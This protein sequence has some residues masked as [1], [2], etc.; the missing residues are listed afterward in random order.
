MK[1]LSQVKSSYQ[2][3][4]MTFKVK[5]SE[6][7]LHRDHPPALVISDPAKWE[8]KIESSRMDEIL[9]SAFLTINFDLKSSS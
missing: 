7:G 9:F 2:A 8:L 1:G 6:T 4:L 5:K 3:Y